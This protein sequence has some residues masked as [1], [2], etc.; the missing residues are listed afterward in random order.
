MEFRLHADYR[1]TGDQPAAIEA[2]D[3][4]LAAGAGGDDA[5]AAFTRSAV[6]CSRTNPK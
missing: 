4:S 3:R 5:I 2:L 1:P 6:T